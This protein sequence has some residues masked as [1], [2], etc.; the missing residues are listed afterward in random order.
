MRQGQPPQGL[1]QPT[2]G[3]QCG[4]LR[5]G[6]HDDHVRQVKGRGGGV[7]EVRTAVHDDGGVLVADRLDDLPGRGLR[8]ELRQLPVLG[9]R[10]QLNAVAHRVGDLGDLAAADLRAQ[11]RQVGDIA[12][13]RDAAVRSEVAGPQVEVHQGGAPAARGRS[14]GH[15]GGQGG[16]HT[17]LGPDDG[18]D[19]ADCARHLLALP[20]D[21]S[22]RGAR[23]GRQGAQTLRVA[24]HRGRQREEAASAGVEH[25]L[26][27]FG[28]RAGGQ[29]AHRQKRLEG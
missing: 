26:D 16:P 3:A 14:R 9:G 25:P 18:D 23:P 13:H 5:S 2:H 19:G 29:E 6:D 20:R 22:L 17:A 12:A 8:H 28:V 4:H 10:Q 21:A 11:G 27:E 7:I 1:P 15:Q 24:L